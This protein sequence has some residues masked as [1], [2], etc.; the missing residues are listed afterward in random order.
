MAAQNKVDDPATA[1]LLSIEDALS[2][3]AIEDEVPDSASRLDAHPLEP[4]Q[5]TT[6]SE[7]ISLATL[8]DHLGVEA[9][10]E[11]FNRIDNSQRHG[12]MIMGYTVRDS[13]TS[14]TRAYTTGQAQFVTP[15]KAGTNRKASAM[16]SDSVVIIK[17]EDLTAVVQASRK[18]FDWT[19]EFTP[20]AG[21]AAALTTPMLKRS[22][23][24][25]RQLEP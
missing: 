10:E 24:G 4:Q 14:F 6:Q 2:F 3:G 18:A 9:G 5:T 25:R 22:S 17:M 8:I 7:G 19:K 15:G 1:A 11:F 12:K 16:F 23:R 21:L 13:R 20:R